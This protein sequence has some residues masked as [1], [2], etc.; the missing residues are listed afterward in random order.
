MKALSEKQ[1]RGYI[2]RAFG[3][4]YAK[5]DKELLDRLKTALENLGVRMFTVYWAQAEP[6]H[7]EYGPHLI[8]RVG[9]RDD[10]QERSS[11]RIRLGPNF[12]ILEN[13]EVQT[14]S[15]APQYQGIG[16]GRNPQSDLRG[17]D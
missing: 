14:K 2:A 5:V 8:V 6:S 13:G 3:L 17:R 1:L 9:I 7:Q 10:V 15:C 4:E 16:K 12:E 11:R